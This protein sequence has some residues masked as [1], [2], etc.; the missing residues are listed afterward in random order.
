[1]RIVRET[2][3]LGSEIF[4]N[5]TREAVVFGAKFMKEDLPYFVELFSEV[6]NET[7]Y[8][9]KWHNAAWAG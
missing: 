6:A 7:R 9:R 5:R 3:L 4:S 1:V 2:E 8:V